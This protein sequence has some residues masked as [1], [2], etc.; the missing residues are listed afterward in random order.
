MRATNNEKLKMIEI[1][2]SMDY[3]QISLMQKYYK[4]FAKLVSAG[5]SELSEL[6]K[7]LKK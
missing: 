1:I 7:E 2:E 5:S 4:D 6:K 3:T